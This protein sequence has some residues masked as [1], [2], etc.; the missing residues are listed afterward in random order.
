MCFFS[1]RSAGVWCLF[2]CQSIHLFVSGNFTLLHRDILEFT[3]PSLFVYYCYYYDYFVSGQIFEFSLCALR[4]LRWF[5]SLVCSLHIWCQYS[6]ISIQWMQVLMGAYVWCAICTQ[7]R[8]PTKCN[9]WCELW[10][11]ETHRQLSFCVCV[12]FWRMNATCSKCHIWR[13]EYS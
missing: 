7:P 9:N 10:F 13:K 11:F 1:F 5:W 6:I 4:K 2:V 3:T 12:W 8:T